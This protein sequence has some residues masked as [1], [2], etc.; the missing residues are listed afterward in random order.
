MMNKVI[1]NTLILISS[2][3]CAFSMCLGIMNVSTAK[4]ETSPIELP[5]FAIYNGASIRP[6]TPVGIRF[7]TGI[8]KEDKAK[9]SGKSVMFGTLIVTKEMYDANPTTALTV[10]NTDA[11]NIGTVNWVTSESTRTAFDKETHEMYFGTLVGPKDDAGWTDFESQYYGTAFAARGYVT[12]EGQ[13][14]IY[15]DVVTRTIAGVAEKA[16]V[17]PEFKDVQAISN[18]VTTAP[19]ITINYVTNCSTNIPSTTVVKGHILTAPELTNDGQVLVGWYTTD[20]FIE[21]T[22]FE[23]DG[24]L[25]NSITVYAK[26]REPTLADKFISDGKVVFSPSV[27]VKS[28][29]ADYAETAMTD[30]T[31]AKE[32]TYKYTATS[33]DGGDGRKLLVNYGGMGG[34]YTAGNYFIIDF[35]KVSGGESVGSIF[36]LASSELAIVYDKNN[37]VIANGS[38]Q[39]NVWYKAVIEIKSE[40]NSAVGTSSA[41]IN[42]ADWTTT[43]LFISSVSI[44]SDAQRKA[45]GMLT[46]G[47]KWEE[48]GKVEFEPSVLGWSG[49]ASSNA[50]ATWGAEAMTG[51]DAREGTYKYKVTAG[52]SGDTRKL[53]VKTNSV[54]GLYVVGNY[55]VLDFYIV[56]G[57]KSTYL[58]LVGGSAFSYY[59]TNNELISGS[60]LETEKWYRGVA[61]ISTINGGGYDDTNIMV[62]DWVNTE[63][64]FSSVS[65]YSETQRKA[66]GMLTAEEKWTEYGKLSFSPSVMNFAGVQTA[67]TYTVQQDGS[68]CYYTN[69]TDGNNGGDGRK[70]LVDTSSLSG[71]YVV[72]NY[73]VLDFSIVSQGSKFGLNNNYLKTGA[74]NVFTVY[75]GEYNV[76][77][78]ADLKTGVNYKAVVKLATIDTASGYDD[79]H[80]MISDWYNTEMLISSFSIYTAGAI[81]NE[82]G[83]QSNI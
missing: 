45:E 46:A 44:Y 2:V 6:D 49:G 55:V 11:V 38:E 83:T 82:F 58:T 19:K 3:I 70:L 72:G 15:T 8:S 27:L 52:S 64:Y 80:I 17:D 14:T 63:V 60:N 5:T 81:E 47:E 33:G 61:K 32:G 1:R 16:S 76:V 66:E 35:Y 26:W 57:T 10:G 71:L 54:S 24:V 62:A 9:L 75:D 25:M 21:G 74:G 31:G 22:E 79:R 36:K 30:L 50:N 18:I 4:A 41:F 77:A 51:D 65:I 40:P 37:N 69:G 59:D 29:T 56:S 13:G 28:G 39:T 42:I 48:Y 7:E 12:I 34:L 73:V 43:E 68:Y 20:N 53:Q 67:N 23:F 78:G